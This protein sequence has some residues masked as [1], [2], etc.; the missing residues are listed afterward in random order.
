MS[1]NTLGSPDAI[2]D[3]KSNTWRQRIN[4]QL[5]IALLEQVDA[6]YP[7]AYGYYL[8][9]LSYYCSELVGQFLETSKI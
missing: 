9:N 2:F 7:L 3:I 6:A 5:T 1:L 4:A 8:F